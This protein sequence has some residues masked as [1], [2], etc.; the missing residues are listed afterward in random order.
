MTRQQA[1]NNRKSPYN[2]RNSPG[3][4]GFSNQY[5]DSNNYNYQPDFNNNFAGGQFAGQ[6]GGAQTDAPIYQTSDWQALRANLVS[7]LGQVESQVALSAAQAPI[8]NQYA[9]GGGAN[10]QQNP[11]QQNPH[12]QNYHYPPSSPPPHQYENFT[13]NNLQN[14][15]SAQPIYDQSTPMQNIKEEM[16]MGEMQTNDKNIN[17][18]DSNEKRFNDYAQTLER[19]SARLEQFEKKYASSQEINPELEELSSQIAQLS[20]QIEQLSIAEGERKNF[21]QFEQQIEKITALLSQ[22]PEVNYVNLNKRLDSLAKN[23]EQLSELQT[24]SV[25]QLINLQSENVEHL[26]KLQEENVEHLRKLQAE[27]IEKLAELQNGDYS[28]KTNIGADFAQN[29]HLIKEN[30][31]NIYERIDKLEQNQGLD[32]QDIER[33]FEEMGAISSETASISQRLENG[34]LEGGTNKDISLILQRVDILNEA[35][36]KVGNNK[37]L[38]G[39]LQLELKSLHEKLYQFIEPNF[40]SLEAKIEARIKELA[41]K[42]KNSESVKSI[43]KLEQ[44]VEKLIVQGNRTSE[45]LDN[46]ARFYR[47]K[48]ED[49]IYEETANPKLLQDIREK[50]TKLLNN[51]AVQLS[52]ENLDNVQYGIEKVDRR[53][54]KL[55]EA[56]RAG[57]GEN[58]DNIN[59]SEGNNNNNF[60]KIAEEDIKGE[61]NRDDKEDNNKTSHDS[62]VGCDGNEDNN[63]FLQSQFNSSL[64]EASALSVE[65]ALKSIKRRIF[66]DDENSEQKNS[67]EEI[68]IANYQNIGRESKGQFENF[69][70][71]ADESDKELDPNLAKEFENIMQEDTSGIIQREFVENELANGDNEERLKGTVKGSEIFANKAKKDEVSLMQEPILS[72]YGT[73]NFKIEKNQ[74]FAPNL[75]E[76]K[77]LIEDEQKEQKESEKAKFSA[78]E[79]SLGDSSIG[80]NSDEENIKSEHN[81]IHNNLANEKPARPRSIFDDDN[82]TNFKG[83]DSNSAQTSS[84]FMKGGEE[85]QKNQYEYEEKNN[86]EQ[87]NFTAGTTNKNTFIEAAR[88]ASILQNKTFIVAP[89]PQSFFEKIIS[90]LKNNNFTT[91]L[92]KAKKQNE[93]QTEPKLDKKPNLENINNQNDPLDGQ[94]SKIDERE[95]VNLASNSLIKNIF[96]KIFTKQGKEKIE[97]ISAAQIEKKPTIS[98]YFRPALLGGALAIIIVLSVNLFFGKNEN[99]NLS[100]SQ[101]DVVSESA[102]IDEIDGKNSEI[103]TPQQPHPIIDEAEPNRSDIERFGVNSTQMEKN[104]T[105]A[106]KPRIIEQNSVANNDSKANETIIIAEPLQV[107]SSQPLIDNSI[108]TSSIGDKDKEADID[109]LVQIFKPSPINLELPDEKIGPIELREAAANGDPRAQFEVGAIYGEGKVIEQDF[110][111]AAKWYERAGASGFAPAALRLGGLYESGKGVEQ[112]YELAKLW[113]QR[114]AEAGNRMAM[115]NLASLYAEGKLGEARFSEAAEWFERA[116]NHSLVDSQFNLGMLYARGLGVKQDLKTAYFWFALAAKNGDKEAAKARDDIARS[117][118]S[119]IIMQVKREVAQW[120]GKEVNIRANFAPIGTWAEK[121]N[122]GPTIRDSEIIKKVQIAL[123]RLGYDVGTPDGLMGPRTKSAIE[124]FERETG[125]SVSGAVNPRL[126]AVLGSQPV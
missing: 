52:E 33:L 84:S 31:A 113:Y 119:D 51:F 36:G 4:H 65:Q 42:I 92:D 79:P 55:E 121:F 28:E 16:Q 26:T 96:S 85:A 62:E 21:A 35:I 76:K 2:W 116:A 47:N 63:N 10:Y 115:H 50:L 100:A 56:L 73:A 1:Q 125:M 68:N 34:D 54:A 46:I 108:S 80:K 124:E 82:E 114:A 40:S 88:R 105:I 94:D 90:K 44:Q 123:N 22:A 112:N 89:E 11:H 99:N 126:L 59:L 98:Q 66:T 70:D 81:F 103:E 15:P 19:I 104:E 86:I 110:A 7:L 58:I 72:Q 37:E 95:Q 38:I 75:Q 117:L 77:H 93:E 57:E 23:V 6:Q 74:P 78:N 30:I 101:D 64:V 24:Q 12:Q 29:L 49:E 53:L 41:Y 71:L 118:N 102:I 107:T 67:L 91:I 14:S 8:N 48:K 45:Q 61:N 60:S 18:N 17:K 106:T 39:E 25:E 120:Q 111:S 27:N 97:N 32:P 5:A 109:E 69:L 43:E 3:G 87:N 13:A 83:E 20:K 9:S 122:P